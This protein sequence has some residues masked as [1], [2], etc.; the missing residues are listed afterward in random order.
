MMKKVMTEALEPYGITLTEFLMLGI[1]VDHGPT[2]VRNTTLA[3]EMRLE[4]PVVTKIVGKSQNLGL[5]EVTP[6]PKDGRAQRVVATN[7]GIKTVNEFDSI[8]NKESALWL[9][10]IDEQKMAVYFEVLN[11]IAAKAKDVKKLGDD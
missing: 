6:D 2:G 9:E 10:D 5:L 1:I 4:M 3:R 7:K 11:S 8:I